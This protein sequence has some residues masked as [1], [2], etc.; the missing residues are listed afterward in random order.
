M[1]Y[2]CSYFDT[3]GFYIDKTYHPVEAAIIGDGQLIHLK[4]AKKCDCSP[5]SSELCQIKF[6]SNHHH[7]LDINRDG[8]SK[9]QLKDMMVRCYRSC[10]TSSKFMVGCRSKE[11]EE[12]LD[13]MGI[14]FVN[15]NHLYGA[16]FNI[17]DT[18]R[19]PCNFHSN[20]SVNYK[21]SL[22]IVQDLSAYMKKYKKGIDVID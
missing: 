17:I 21:C 4:V 6:L 22:S 18:K 5:T 1:D 15:V 2:I 13:W 9:E 19:K 14:P 16:T 7:G 11:S 20:N 8:V 3:Q 10:R 12:L